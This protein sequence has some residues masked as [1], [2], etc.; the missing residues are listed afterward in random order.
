M[1]GSS[2]APIQPDR[3]LLD[4]RFRV[5]RFLGAAVMALLCLITLAN[6]FVRYFTD[7]SF[8]FT[9]EVSVALMVVMTFVASA[10]A[11]FDGNQIAVTWFT[12]FFSPSVRRALVSF[13]LLASM[14][15]FAL[16]TWLGGRMAWDDFQYEVT[17]P[18][19]GVPQWF[20]TVWLPIL[21]LLLVARL[22]QGLRDYLR[23][24]RSL[25]SLR[26]PRDLHD[27]P[28]RAP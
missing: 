10:R 17:S 19:I 24:V 8:A 14:L 25:R 4:R 27:P 3:A 7:F 28:R 2:N 1:D 12:E 21:S 15:M 23:S 5:E 22:A 20:Y 16:L 18:G 11:F 26:D 9:E 13:S 6:V